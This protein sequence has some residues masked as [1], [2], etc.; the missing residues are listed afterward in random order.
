MSGADAAQGNIRLAAALAQAGDKPG[1][2]AA[3]G[4]VTSGS[5]APIA[6]YWR[7]WIESPATS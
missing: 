7:A 2:L 1:A 5:Y 3:L 6:T 4:N